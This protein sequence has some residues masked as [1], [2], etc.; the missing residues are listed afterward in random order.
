MCVHWLVWF[1]HQSAERSEMYFEIL[2][3]KE[4]LEIYDAGIH[5]ST[6][7]LGSITCESFAFIFSLRASHQFYFTERIKV[8]DEGMFGE[9]SNYNRFR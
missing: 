7:T 4:Y 9:S 3:I 1:Q 5:S 2:S 8:P 6:Y